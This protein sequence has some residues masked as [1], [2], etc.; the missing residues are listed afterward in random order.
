MEVGLAKKGLGIVR[1]RAVSRLATIKVAMMDMKLLLHMSGKAT[2]TPTERL[3]VLRTMKDLALSWQEMKEAISSF[4]R[5]MRSTKHA[6]SKALLASRNTQR[7]QQSI[8]MLVR[9]GLGFLAPLSSAE[10]IQASIALHRTK[11]VKELNAIKVKGGFN[12]SIGR[13]SFPQLTKQ[14]IALVQAKAKSNI[15]KL[16]SARSRLRLLQ[17]RGRRRF[18]P[19]LRRGSSNVIK[20]AKK[21]TAKDTSCLAASAT[22]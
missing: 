8:A 14:S 2:L 16:A 3:V 17:L 4:D 19:H 1:D 15:A 18:H 13:N 7:I 5:S 10:R 12:L 6:R 11:K 22:Y 21:I 9:A 20:N